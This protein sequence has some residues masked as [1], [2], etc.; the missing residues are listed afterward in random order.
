MALDVIHNDSS[1]I[2]DII[3]RE[4]GKEG[5]TARKDLKR[6]S[7]LPRE[8]TKASLPGALVP[9][10]AIRMSRIAP[11]PKGKLIHSPSDKANRLIY[12]KKKSR[13]DTFLKLEGKIRP[14][15]KA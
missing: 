3:L 2:E 6:E 4:Y 11:V 13:V 15:N 5:A 8:A 1:C 10:G 12:K 9:V 7:F 14:T